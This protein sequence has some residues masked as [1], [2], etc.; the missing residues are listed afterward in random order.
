MSGVRQGPSLDSECVT[1]VGMQQTKPPMIAPLRARVVPCPALFY[2]VFIT[3]RVT[4]WSMTDKQR[5]LP[6]IHRY[7]TERLQTVPANPLLIFEGVVV[8]AV[9]DRCCRGITAVDNKRSQSRDGV[10]G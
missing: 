3:Q 6:G 10:T 5:G 4:V 7:S 8:E 2:K 1:A 9:C